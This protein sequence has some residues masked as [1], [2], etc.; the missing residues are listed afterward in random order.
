MYIFLVRETAM[1]SDVVA[2][3][4]TQLFKYCLIKMKCNAKFSS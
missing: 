2:T 4:H 3:S 1:L